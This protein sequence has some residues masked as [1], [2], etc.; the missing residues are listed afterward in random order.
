MNTTLGSV[1]H[2]HYAGLRSAVCS[3]CLV[4]FLSVRD[5][6]FLSV[7]SL[8]L[9][10]DLLLPLWSFSVDFKPVFVDDFN[11]LWPMFCAVYKRWCC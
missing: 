10:V 6:F 2:E 11:L 7:L 8:F 9:D 4:F 5:P 1:L 3:L